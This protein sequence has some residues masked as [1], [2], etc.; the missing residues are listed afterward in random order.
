MLR[1]GWSSRAVTPV[2]ATSTKALM[3]VL[4]GGGAEEGERV[5]GAEGGPEQERRRVPGAA[6]GE[7]R[8][9]GGGAARGVR[10]RPETQPADQRLEAGHPRRRGGA[11]P[12]LSG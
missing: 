11:G 2:R 5:V 3:A 7:A 6:A 1:A 10:R 12:A 9:E 4:R 8:V